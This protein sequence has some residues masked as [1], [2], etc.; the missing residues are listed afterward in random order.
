MPHLTVHA[1]EPQ[2]AGREPELISALTEA[3][4]QVYGDWARDLVV[5]HLDGIPPGRWGKGGGQPEDPPPAITFGIREGALT[6]PNGDEFADRLVTSVT[7]AVAA[8]MGDH[9]RPGITVELVATP[10]GRSAEGGV[11]AR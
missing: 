5:V 8:V 11:I 4:A 3:V 1:L 6:R 2:I 9:L 10:P 7:N